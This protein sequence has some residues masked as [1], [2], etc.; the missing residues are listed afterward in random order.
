MKKLMIAGVAGLCAAVTFAL[1]SANVVGYQTRTITTG[2]SLSTPTFQDVGECDIDLQNF[3]LSANAAGDGTEV[4]QFLDD[5]G[6]CTQIWIWLNGNV[7]YEEG[8]YDFYTWEPI[9]QKINPGVGYLMNVGADVDIITSGQVKA[10]DT[11]VT[12]PAGFSVHGNNTPTDINLQTMK[13]G[14]TAAG[15][16]T[17][18][19]QF[20]D[21]QGQCTQIWIWLNGN[22]GYEEG[23]Y[24]FY[25]WE[26]ISYTV[27]AGE[28]FLLN[29]VSDV[30]MTIPS[31]L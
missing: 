20:L 6:Q 10:E 23:W 8:W 1:E 7:G 28:A 13:L 14:A 29:V 15:D 9:T 30:E 11:V 5:Q 18:V 2:F 16:G 26:P 22:V 21:D 4:I 19:I 25:T 27:K 3:K 12:I 24:D 31:A 17:E